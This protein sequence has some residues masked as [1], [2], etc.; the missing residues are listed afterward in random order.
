MKKLMETPDFKPGNL[1]SREVFKNTNYMLYN[2]LFIP[3]YDNDDDNN[4]ILR[5]KV[6]KCLYVDRVLYHKEEFLDTSISLDPK[7]H[8]VYDYYDYGPISENLEYL[9]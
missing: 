7:N 2:I 3:Y 5:G 1:Y 4:R 6:I 8:S 9:I